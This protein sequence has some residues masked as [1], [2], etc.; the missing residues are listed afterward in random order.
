MTALNIIDWILP[1]KRY[2]ENDKSSA[3]A[4]RAFS[5]NQ[6]R[7]IQLWEMVVRT[8][9]NDGHLWSGQCARRYRHCKRRKIDW[10]RVERARTCAAGLIEFVPCQNE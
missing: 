5:L 9:G 1:V 2:R 7:Q 8:A 10:F 4:R 6:N 3:L